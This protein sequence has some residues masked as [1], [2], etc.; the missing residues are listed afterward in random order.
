MA[1]EHANRA[2]EDAQKNLKRY[3]EQ[4]KELQQQVDENQRSRQEFHEKYLMMDKRYQSTRAEQQE[5]V[6]NLETVCACF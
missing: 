4:V 6:A 2:N 5:L 1:L 3:A